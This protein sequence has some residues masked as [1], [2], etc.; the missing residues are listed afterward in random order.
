MTSKARY[1]SNFVVNTSNIADGAIT[2]AKLSTSSLSTSNVVEGS[3]LYFTNTRARSAISISGAG[4][5]DNSTGVITIT[6]GVTSVGGATG[7]V[8]NAQLLA[9]FTTSVI[10]GTSGN[11][12]TSDGT[13]WVSRSASNPS[14]NVLVV[15]RST[16][17][18]IPLTN[19]TINIV[20]RTG[21]VTVLVN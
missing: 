3:S 21:N 2:G 5:Y 10:P 7:A 20:S 17:T 6:G 9:G 18:F 8:S 14:Q 11:V 19:G 13:G 4:S 16:S 15:G 12:L 1:I